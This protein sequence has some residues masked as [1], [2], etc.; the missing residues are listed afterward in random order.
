M[1]KILI[2]VLVFGAVSMSVYAGWGYCWKCSC[3]GYEQPF[4][5][6]NLCRNCGHSYSHHY[7]TSRP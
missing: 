4:G 5:G 6:G 1:T 2:A 3:N 7:N